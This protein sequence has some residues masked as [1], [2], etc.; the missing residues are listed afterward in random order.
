MLPIMVQPPDLEARVTALEAQ[1]RDWTN[2]CVTTGR[3][4]PQPACWPVAQI[5]T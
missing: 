2:G 1:V 4:L 3:T 5:A